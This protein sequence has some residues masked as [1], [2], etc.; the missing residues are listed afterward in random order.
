MQR[1]GMQSPRMQQAI[2]RHKTQTQQ[3][4]TTKLVFTSIYNCSSMIDQVV[5]CRTARHVHSQNNILFFITPWPFTPSSSWPTRTHIE[6][7][8]SCAYK[9]LCTNQDRYC[10]IPNDL[11]PGIASATL[12]HNDSTFGHQLT[13]T[14]HT[15][16]AL[17]YSE[18]QIQPGL[19]VYPDIFKNG[20]PR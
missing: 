15:F 17:P 8:H 5:F 11:I 20:N 1:C 10:I 13:Y 18:L 16:W 12:S 4:S 6:D 2:R 9:E 14:V 19:D 3:I 7:F